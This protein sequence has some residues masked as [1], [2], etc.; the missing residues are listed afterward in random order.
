VSIGSVDILLPGDAEADV[1]E[2]YGLPPVEIVLVPHHGSSG[3]VSS[4][5]LDHLK[6][7]VAV[8]SVG[9]NNS[10]GHPHSS[11]VS[12]LEE[13]VGLVLRTDQS[14]WVSFAMAGDRFVLTSE[15]SPDNE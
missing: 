10:F 15:R 12:I 14:G 8:I 2:C 6:P 9:R 11:S 1:L 7:K 4:V 3:A 13:R 5:L